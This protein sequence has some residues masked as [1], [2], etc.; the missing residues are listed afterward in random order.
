MDNKGE[1]LVPDAREVVDM[2]KN[3]SQPDRKHPHESRFPVDTLAEMAR[4]AGIHKQRQEQGTA[5]LPV[6]GPG[7]KIVVTKET[8]WLING[9]GGRRFVPNEKYVSP[10]SSSQNP[11]GKTTVETQK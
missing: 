6:L 4:M 9:P 10:P 11:P 3:S 8:G 1:I 7:E 2:T 5:N